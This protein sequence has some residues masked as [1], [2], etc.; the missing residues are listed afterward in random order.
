M[1][2]PRA[3]RGLAARLAALTHCDVAVIDYRLAPEHAYPA[4]PDDAIARVSR[5]V[6]ARHRCV[7][8]RDRRRL[9]RRQPCVGHVAA[10]TRLQV[11]VAERSR[12][13]VAVDRPH[14]KRR[15]DAHERKTRSDAAGPTDR[16][17]RADVRARLQISTIPTYRRCSATSRACRPSPFMLARPKSCSTI[18]G[19]SRERAQDN[20][21]F[22]SSCE[23][24]HRMPH[25]FPMFADFLPE[26]R[27]ALD[28]IGEFIGAR[29]P[30]QPSSGFR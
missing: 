20:T 10:R 17:S 14:R 21:A 28:E 5:I 7:V 18:R 11:A 29:L 9:G 16:R 27:R 8:D 30:S 6:V 4:A 25:V 19:G 3:Y 13:A 22:A 15:L 23:T 26:G 2:S 24:W 12:A 1:G